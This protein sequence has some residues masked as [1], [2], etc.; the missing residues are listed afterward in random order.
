M[1]EYIMPFLAY[2]S[3]I[4]IASYFFNSQ[5]AYAFHVLS[6]IILLS[7]FWKK[8]RLKFNFDMPAV[9]TGI[10]IFLIWIGL[11][12]YYPHLYK[13]E[14]RPLSNFFLA[15]KLIG[16]IF[17]APAVEE[18]FT[19]G[20][21]ARILLDNDWRKIPVGKFTASSFI[22]TTLFFGFSHNRWLVGI[23]TGIILNVLLMKKKKVE[24]CIIAHFTA[25]LALAAYIIYTSS[26]FLW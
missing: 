2:I 3:I 7:I 11:E 21:L 19:R 12:N 13:I 9:F 6:A 26:W 1:K 5:I 22:I 25:N 18:L 23:I 14:F 10:A 24:S 20:F 17:I 4:P 15:A 8:Y 16:F